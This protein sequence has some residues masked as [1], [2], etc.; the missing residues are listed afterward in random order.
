MEIT[1]VGHAAYDYIFIVEKHPGMDESVYI[2]KWKKFYG[3]GGANIA[4]GF[5]HL[6]GKSTLYTVAGSDFG[7][8]EKYLKRKGVK[9]LLERSEKRTASAFIFND[10]S[11][12]KSYFFWGASEDMKKMKGIK[13]KH[14]HIAPCHP[15]LAMKMAEKSEFFAFEPGQDLRKYTLEELSYMVEN[16]G[17]IFCNER[18]YNYMR[19]N[20][21]LQGKD[22]V[23][24]LGGRG[25]R[26]YRGEKITSI[27]AVKAR[28]FIDA[29]GAG[30]A[31]KAAFWYA[32][33]KGKDMEKCCR[34]AS[35][36]ASFVV[37][38][39]GAQI[40]PSLDRILKRYERSFGEKF[41]QQ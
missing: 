22:V 31:Y 5:S 6:G 8:Y 30:D 23:V 33:L 3:G 9:T 28:R 16:A 17:I 24:T 29:T 38:R 7:R 37:E 12:Q 21:S 19:K 36:F 32:F 10:P 14:L 35:V 39:M 27:K 13:S 20:I 18:E 40:Y 4:T 34:F 26:I 11:T 25:S 1:V 2:K 15:E 41:M